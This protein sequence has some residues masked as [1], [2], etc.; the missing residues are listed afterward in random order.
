MFL[1]NNI[2][3]KIKTLENNSRTGRQFFIQASEC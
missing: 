1:E 2:F 3:L